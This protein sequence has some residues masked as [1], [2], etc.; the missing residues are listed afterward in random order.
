MSEQQGTDR[1]KYEF[2]FPQSYSVLP[3]G[4][5]SAYLGVST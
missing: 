3:F 2:T 5:I 1:Q 4:A